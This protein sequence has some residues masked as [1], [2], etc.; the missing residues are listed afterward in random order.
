M[1]ST[2][3]RETFSA[4]PKNILHTRFYIPKKH[5]VSIA[6]MPRKLVSIRQVTAIRP[7]A[8]ERNFYLATVDGWAC[9]IPKDCFAVGDYGV[10]FEIDSFLPSTLQG[11]M[12]YPMPWEKFRG[13]L[14]RRIKTVNLNGQI[15]QGHLV[16]LDRFPLIKED[17]DAAVQ[18]DLDAELGIVKYDAGDSSGAG[19]RLGPFPPFIS[20][21]EPPHLQNMPGDLF[22]AHADTLFQETAITKGSP[23]TVYYLRSGCAWLHGF[24]L[25]SRFGV[26]SHD[27]ELSEDRGPYWCVTRRLSF[28]TRACLGGCQAPNEVKWLSSDVLGHPR[29]VL[30]HSAAQDAPPK[31]ITDSEYR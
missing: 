21:P 16:P 18:R 10:F 24:P 25:V 6:S 9:A 7:I 19:L 14:G 30:K 4:Q 13:M 5:H 15:S 29:A 20:K 31:T 11:D 23:M 3:V 17:T 1:S 2:G 26:C 27:G 8:F 22:L 12:A 28:P